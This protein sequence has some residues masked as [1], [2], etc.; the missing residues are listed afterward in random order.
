M[1]IF[2]F[3]KGKRLGGENLGSFIPKS[4]VFVV[5]PIDKRIKNLNERRLPWQQQKTVV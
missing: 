1:G 4:A 2:S 5:S 3:I